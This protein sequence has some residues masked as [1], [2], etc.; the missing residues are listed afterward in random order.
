MKIVI[1]SVFIFSVMSA[2]LANGEPN[3]FS[4]VKGNLHSA[5]DMDKPAIGYHSL[6]EGIGGYGGTGSLNPQTPERRILLA[7]DNPSGTQNVSPNKPKVEVFMTSWCGYCRKMIQFLREKGIPYTAY[8]I[9]KD[10]AAA[11]KYD[12]I[13]GRGVP[14]VRVGS[15]IVFG[16]GPEAVLSYYN[17]EN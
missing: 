7:Q 13:G 1:C 12:E 16:Y 9:E 2:G 8:D 6:T 11:E 5:P 15:H 14:V 3:S 4:M 10:S 17:G